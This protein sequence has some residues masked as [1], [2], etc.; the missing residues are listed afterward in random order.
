[1]IKVALTGNIA[2]GKSEVQN[3]LL[4][5]GYTVMDTDDCAHELLNNNSDVLKLFGTT[6]RSALAKIVFNDKKKLN[7]LEQILHPLVKN[8]ILDFFNSNFNLPV[9]FV[10][11][12]QLFE[13]GFE[14]LFDKI[15]FVDAPYKLRLDRLIKRNGYSEDY[16][17]LR[18][19]SQAAADKKILLSDFV[20]VNSS[21]LSEL[22]KKTKE[23]LKLL[24]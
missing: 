10:A 21:N 11:V 4:K 6:D 5:L 23:C 20:I 3:I 13:S 18:L 14:K 19:D 9:I 7:L 2:A 1:M 12:P 8:K 22:E 15:I 24:L 16:A 17:K